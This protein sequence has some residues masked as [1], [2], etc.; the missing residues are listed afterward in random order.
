MNSSHAKSN[1]KGAV[2]NF[3]YIGLGANLGDPVGQVIAA[4]RSLT[5]LKEVVHCRSSAI[6]LSSPVGYD[7]QPDFANC[8]LRLEV[9]CGYRELFHCMQ[10]IEQNMGRV[11]DPDNQN[12]ARLIDI[13]F[14]LYGEQ[15]CSEKKDGEKKYGEK[16]YVEKNIDEADLIVPHP[17]MSDRLFVL[18][19]LAELDAELA[20]KY[21]K[22][23]LHDA[24]SL[25]KNFP[26]QAL[27][28]LAL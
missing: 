7:E 27:F 11:R 22:N 10:K 13:D 24:H 17:R 14:L 16:K 8:V 9:C 2:F 20:M 1:Q 18:Q 26:S 19:P 21:S 3:A 5:D 28:R 12:S 25:G 4:R 15:L 6:Y 23:K